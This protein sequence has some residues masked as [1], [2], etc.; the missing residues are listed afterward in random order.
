MKEIFCLKEHNYSTRR[1]QLSCEKPSTVTHGLESFKYKAGQIWRSLPREIQES[2][3]TSI[4]N[5]INSHFRAI[6][7]CNLCKPDI[8]HLG[9]I[10]NAK[11]VSL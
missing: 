9:Y 11:L 5:Y 1:Q 10:E 3:R 8:P 7:N 2:D 4:I 6:C